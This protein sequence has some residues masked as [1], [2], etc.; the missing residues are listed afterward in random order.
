[1]RH[2]F[3]K[4]LKIKRN[5]IKKDL[6]YFAIPSLIIFLIG[7]VLC[8]Q[9]GAVSGFWGNVWSVVIHPN[10]L[11]IL[12]VQVTTGMILIISGLIIMLVGQVTLWKN[13]SG[14]V[15]IRKDHK[16]ITHGIYSFSRNPIYLGA[17]IVVVIGLPIY[18]ASLYGF[19]T[20]SLLIPV[21]LN[22]IRMEEKLL[23][24]EFQD[25]FKKYRE[26][27][28]KLFPFIY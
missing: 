6:I 26:S 3:L 19:F 16:L 10:K 27:T 9:E 23:T 8:D 21:T 20:L 15:I 5:D 11:S 28:K 18:A 1:M 14:T 24:E 4:K 22:R 7:L 2:K 17:I 12:P 25:D 13:Y